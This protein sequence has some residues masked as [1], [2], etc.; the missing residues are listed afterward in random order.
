[1]LP[2][3]P[4]AIMAG[5]SLDRADSRPPQSRRSD[6]LR[7]IDWSDLSI[8]SP[9]WFRVTGAIVET[10]PRLQDCRAALLAEGRLSQAWPPWVDTIA[11]TA[12]RLNEAGF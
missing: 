10:G 6:P 3:S 12:S 7:R 9:K 1:V 5:F 11:S 4:N 8:W 2:P